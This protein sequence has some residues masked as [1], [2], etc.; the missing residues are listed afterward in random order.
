MVIISVTLDLERPRSHYFA[1]QLGQWM[2]SVRAAKKEEDEGVVMSGCRPSV[3]SSVHPSIRM[4][5]ISVAPL[6]HIDTRERSLEREL[7]SSSTTTETPPPPHGHSNIPP[8]TVIVQLNHA[9]ASPSPYEVNN[10]IKQHLQLE[11]RVGGYAAQD[12]VSIDH[13]QSFSSSL[14]AG[15]SFPRTLSSS[16]AASN[17]L[18]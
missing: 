16:F 1:K 2:S 12:Q 17:F 9:G 8:T 14:L 5:V 4:S 3:R 11:E 7:S 10:R 6:L 15:P 18:P 13:H